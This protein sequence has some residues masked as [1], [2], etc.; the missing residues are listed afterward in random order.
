MKFKNE[1]GEV[2]WKNVKDSTAKKFA[3]SWANEMERMLNED[4]MSTI[5]G[6][7]FEAFESCVLK[8]PITGQEECVASDLLGQYWYRGN[9]LYQ[10]WT[11][12]GIIPE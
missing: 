11:E 4:A 8:V 1:T 10:L 5:E 2:E 3:E 7:A 9:E 6:V 12:G